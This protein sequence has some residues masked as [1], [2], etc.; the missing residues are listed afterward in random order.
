MPAF[1]NILDSVLNNLLAPTL[2]LRQQAC[3]ALGGIVL[4]LVAIPR[5]ST[6]IHTRISSIIATYITQIP[7]SPKSASSSAA[8]PSKLTQEAP[9][10]RT[11]RATL[12]ATEPV[13]AAQGPVWALVVL[14]CFIVLLGPTLV[15]N[16]KIFR[17]LSSMLS[18]SM[19]HKK[20]SVRALGCMVWRCVAWVYFLPSSDST[21]ENSLALD[22]L[23]DKRDSI[24]RAL[25]NVVDVQ[26]GMAVIAAVLG[27]ESID[28]DDSLLRMMNVLENMMAKQTN[29]SDAIDTMKR[30]VSLETG[31]V[32]WNVNKLLMPAIFAASPGLLTVEYKSLSVTVNDLLLAQPP[33]EDI[34][35][36][37]RDEIAQEWVFDGMIKL[38]KQAL[39]SLKKFDETEASVSEL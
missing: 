4:G 15:H 25:M 11:L 7:E 39:A 26:T 32:Q 24:W 27:D 22:M 37:S 23:K 16:N 17:S 38:W 10:F 8:S 34:R 13:H 19:R 12:N 33:L 9:I 35:Y 6:S 28:S 2:G 5:S 20:S 14:A 30:L 3:H 36:L 21:R 18:L 1:T 31:N 29:I